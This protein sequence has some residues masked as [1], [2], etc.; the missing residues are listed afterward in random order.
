MR[1]GGEDTN[2][3]GWM[4]CLAGN[5]D[6]KH[7]S[8]ADYLVVSR[9]SGSLLENEVT[10][11]TA[12]THFPTH[13]RISAPSCGSEMHNVTS[14]DIAAQAKQ[15]PPQTGRRNFPVK[16]KNDVPGGFVAVASLGGL[17]KFDILILGILRTNV[18]EVEKEYTNLFS[19][20]IFLL[21]KRNV[22]SAI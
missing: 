7:V 19:I 9:P 3:G 10:T 6:G 8:E 18:K 12:S 20:I 17:I 2:F 11:N 1:P 14:G 16:V 15:L 13:R 21:L 5:Q 22:C 4:L